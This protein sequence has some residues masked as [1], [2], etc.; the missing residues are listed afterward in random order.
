MLLTVQTRV[1]IQKVI[2]AL[3][4]E[5]KRPGRQAD[6][7]P[8]S[9]VKFK[10]DGAKPPLYLFTSCRNNFTFHLPVI[11]LPAIKHKLW[12]SS[13]E[14]TLLSLPVKASPKREKQ[15]YSLL[16]QLRPRY[17]DFRCQYHNTQTHTHA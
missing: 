7:S 13:V 10:N 15:K 8:P 9:G 17:C 16:R 3:S 12:F 11:L 2:K 6:H 4:P 5:V 14:N 1:P